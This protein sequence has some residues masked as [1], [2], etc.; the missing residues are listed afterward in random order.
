MRRL[1]YE[2]RNQSPVWSPD[3]KRLAFQ[4][5]REGDPALFVQNADGTGAA[6][7]LTRPEKGAAHIPESWSR[8]GRY[9]SFSITKG[10]TSSLWILAVENG[11]I[12]KFGDVQSVEPI[13]ST[14]SPD[15]RWI[16]YHVRPEGAPPTAPSVG[17][18]VQPFP[19]TGELSQ[20]PRVNIDFQPVWS[21]DGRELFYIPTTVSGR[22]AAVRFFTT[23]MVGFGNP[24]SLPFTLTAGRLSNST[25]AFDVLPN[26]RFVGLVGGN[27]DSPGT[28]ANEVRLVFNWFEELKRLAPAN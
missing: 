25:R 9:L 23:P 11:T 13:G 4:S 2:G 18:F 24:E 8:D 19:A 16:A 28:D 17:V 5:D 10:A 3:G 21:S 12:L 15:G 27:A 14:F 20:A 6:V 1:T 7:R 22:I 26:G